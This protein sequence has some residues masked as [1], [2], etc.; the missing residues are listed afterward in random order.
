MTHKAAT[1]KA[2]SEEDK[3]NLN[4]RATQEN[5]SNGYDPKAKKLTHDQLLE[6]YLDK[7]EKWVTD[8]P[9]TRGEKPERPEKKNRG[10]AKPPKASDNTSDNSSD[11]S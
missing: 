2:L 4:Q 7:L 8:D 3:A 1:W 5:K 11:T 6:A 9:E 10:A